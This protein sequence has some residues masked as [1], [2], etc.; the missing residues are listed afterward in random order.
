MTLTTNGIL[1]LVGWTGDIAPDSTEWITDGK[2]MLRLE[3]LPLGLVDALRS[4]RGA[5]HLKTGACD[6]APQRF[7]E[8]WTGR[9]PVI[10]ADD[11]SPYGFLDLKTES[12]TWRFATPYIATVCHAC[13]R[14]ELFIVQLDK[15]GD[16]EQR[17]NLLNEPA[18][19]H[20]LVAERDG[21]V[22]AM[23]MGVSVEFDCNGVDRLSQ[24]EPEQ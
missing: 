17:V 15:T 24:P 1:G 14:A 9:E 5:H 21:R 3:P 11:E 19:H 6:V 22:M 7:A 4:E 18:L 20:M 12:G 10:G 2:L 8:Q 13:D 16:G 23:L